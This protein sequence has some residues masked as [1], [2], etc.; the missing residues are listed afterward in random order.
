MVD[1]DHELAIANQLRVHLTRDLGTDDSLPTAGDTTEDEGIFHATLP[2][3]PINSSTD[4][5]CRGCLRL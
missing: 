1:R 5:H 3:Q 4:R 2:Q